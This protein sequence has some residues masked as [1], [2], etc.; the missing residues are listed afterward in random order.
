M[1]EE[2][3]GRTAA[4]EQ[5]HIRGNEIS[6]TRRRVGN[7]KWRAWRSLSLGGW[8]MN[9]PIQEQRHRALM[10][11]IA[12]IVMEPRMEGRHRR[13]GLNQQEDTQA[14]NSGAAFNGAHDLS[15]RRWHH[16]G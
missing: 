16:G 14:K 13:H 2:S 5:P 6:A 12:G 4:G 9:L 1:N 15:G 3:G 10:V 8:A 7:K 11:G